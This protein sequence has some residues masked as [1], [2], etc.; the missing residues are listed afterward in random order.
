M[1]EGI[2]PS[3]MPSR[4]EEHPDEDLERQPILS[5]SDRLGSGRISSN[6][7]GSG[8]VRLYVLKG[9]N[10]APPFTA[11][12]SIPAGAAAWWRQPLVVSTLQNLGLILLWYFFGTFLSLWNK[13][14]LGKDKGLFGN[15]AF[16]APFLMSS[17]QFF[18][19]HLL[20][21]FLLSTGCVRRRSEDVLTWRQY[22]RTIVPNGMA[23]ALDIGFSNFSLV[24]ITLSFYVMCKSTTPI[25]LLFFAI[26]WGIEK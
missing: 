17:V 18:C 2:A 24:F 15:G 19:Q 26:L 25:F 12:R 1:L 22:C 20:A 8:N 14:L 21:G 23:T 10:G 7:S 5:G 9:T 4:S 11:P 6:G 3:E 16:P 13:M